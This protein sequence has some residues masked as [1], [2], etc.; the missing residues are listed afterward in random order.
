[1]KYS[2][3]IIRLTFVIVLTVSLFAGY[4]QQIPTGGYQGGTHGNIMV[5]E[6]TGAVNDN[7]NE[8]PCRRSRRT[9]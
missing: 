5:K 1:M 6:W 9:G 4:S 7:W 3:K 2:N 8:V